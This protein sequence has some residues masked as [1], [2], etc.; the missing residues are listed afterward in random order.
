MV[1]TFE[2]VEI[3]SCGFRCYYSGEQIL[4]FELCLVFCAGDSFNLLWIRIKRKHSLIIPPAF[5][6]RVYSFQFPF[7][8][9]FVHPSGIWN[10]PQSF[11]QSCVKVSQAGI[12]HKILIIKLAFIFGPL[13]PWKVCFHA[14]SFGPGVHAPG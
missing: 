4:S 1:I 14:M 2:P 5:M 6:S 10:L 7:V 9:S 8:S 13:V 12:S 3:F 11:Q